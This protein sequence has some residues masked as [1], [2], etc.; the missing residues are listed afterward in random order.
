[1]KTLLLRSILLAL[2]MVVRRAAKKHQSVRDKLQSGQCVVQLRM[3]DGSLCRHYVFKNG[4]VTGVPGAHCRPDSEMVFASV[5]TALAMVNPHPDYAV[6]IDALKN[7]KASA[8]GADRWTV[9]FGQLMHLV[10]SAAWEYGAPQKDGSLRYTNLTNGGPIHVYVRDGRII[11]TTPIEFD[12]TDAPSW[13]IRARG[14]TFSPRRTAT[15]SP[16]ALALKSMVYSPK[17][18][19]YPMKRVDFDPA[20]ERNTGQRG[21]S[22]YVRITWEEALTI[23]AGEILRMKREHGPGAIAIAQPAHH[24]W[25]NINYW[26]SALYRFGNL[27]GHTKVAF[28]PISWEGWYWGAMHHY[29]N[30]MRL[31]VP[32]FY[33]TTEDCLKEADLI[34]FWSSDPESTGGIYAGYE[35]TQRRLWAKELGIEFVHIDPSL[36]HTA[37]LLGGKW[38]PI[39]PGTDSALAMAVMYEWIVHELYDRDYVTE[40]TTGFDEW[41]DYL[42]G[43]SDGIP[44]T[45][46]WQEAETGVP[47]KDARSLARI[48]GSRKTYLAAGGLGAGFGGACRSAT[49]AQ[50]ARCMVLMMA[51][52]GWGKPGI[53]FGNLQLGVPMDLNFYFP[54]YAEGGIS[55]DITHT[56]SAPHNYVRMPHVLTMNAVKQTIPRQRLPEAIIDG[57]CSGYAWD[58]FSLEGQFSRFEYPAPGHSRMHMLYRYGSSSLG[59]IPDSGRFIEAYRHPSLEFV[60]NQ[61][62]WMENEAQ[63]ADIILPACTSLERWDISEWANCAGFL[64]HG[65]NQVNHRTVIMQHKCIE[66]LGESKSDYQIFLDILTRL[67]LGALFSEGGCTE[68]DWCKRIF[69]SSD[70]PKLVSWKDFLK[71]GYQVIHPGSEASQAP[72]D[73]R[74]FAE[75]QSKNVPEP[76]PLPA[77]YSDEFGKGL[78]TQSGKFEF[79]AQ[80]LRRFEAE[81]PERPA[82]N[83]YLAS[84]EGR[85]NPDQAVRFPLQLITAHPRYSFHTYADGK[86]SSVSDIRDHRILVGG[87]RYWVVR[88]NEGDAAKRGIR[89]HDLVKV[90][91]SRGAV[92]CAA[93]V[94]ATVLPG[95]VGAY[96]S[97]AEFDLIETPEGLVDRGGCLNLLTP[98]RTM[99]KTADGIA[100][101]S[102]LVEVGKWTRAPVQAA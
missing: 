29:G 42:L 23:V 22:G 70:L 3:R 62:I 38:L 97:S 94:T 13:T 39:R 75:G 89:Q 15:V 57:H 6:I 99:S 72:V 41:R 37:Q 82:L 96:E 45:P 34:V 81:D 79:V 93:D 54:G 14:R 20:G 17:R 59:T 65:Q 50:W 2:P 28:S 67:G 18:L 76:I 5:D 91:N 25:G 21:V 4:T 11:R 51:M 84:W 19:L 73:M 27:I 78:P 95:V 69:D 101:N 74:W 68:L 31:G 87:F 88:I 60:V 33:G 53:N 10:G 26:L 48:W 90:H 47:A 52:Q 8:A 71:K 30:N 86:E 63:F 44:K 36:N 85:G 35:G 64:H 32:G 80:S 66:P 102:C 83:R 9:W 24:Q 46:E 12:A 43:V 49:G 40:K 58:G 56:G 61:S 77:Q 55:G 92:I 1:M 100:P 7:F 16:H 98:G